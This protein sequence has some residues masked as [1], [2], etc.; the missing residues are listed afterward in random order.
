[1]PAAKPKRCPKC[2]SSN[3]KNPRYVTDP[4]TGEWLKWEC[5]D[6]G[7]STLLPCADAKPCA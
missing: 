2:E 3:W 6:C 4:E 5:G 1:M 7:Y